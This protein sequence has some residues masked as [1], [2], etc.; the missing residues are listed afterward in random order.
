MNYRFFFSV[1]L[2]YILTNTFLCLADN[3]T[4]PSHNAQQTQCGPDCVM[5]IL[6]KNNILVT[7]ETIFYKYTKKRA[8]RTFL[9][10]KNLFESFGFKVTGYQL[11]FD[12]LK[13]LEGEIICHY[14]NKHFVILENIGNDFVT[15]YNPPKKLMILSRNDFSKQ[16]DGNVLVIE[17]S[18]DLVNIIEEYP[19]SRL[20]ADIQEYHWGVIRNDKIIKYD[21]E[22]YNL[23]NTPLKIL[24]FKAP[25]SCLKAEFDKRELQSLEKGILTVAFD[26]QDRI[27]ENSVN[28][29]VKTNDS[30][31]PVTKFIME[32]EIRRDL[33]YSPKVLNLG[34]F[35]P[36]SSVIRRVH[37]TAAGKDFLKI[38]DVKS[39]AKNI[40]LKRIV[41]FVNDPY[42]KAVELEIA[43]IDHPDHFEESV[44]ISFENE[45]YEPVSVIIRGSYENSIQ[46]DPSGVFL[47]YNKQK[48]DFKGTLTLKSMVKNKISVNSLSSNIDFLK[49]KINNSEKPQYLTVEY[50]GQ[51]PESLKDGLIGY[52]SIELLDI[53][54]TELKIPVFVTK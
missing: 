26:T 2:F 32:G 16:W 54:T 7:P 43:W 51:W 49:L 17:N 22:F 6:H 33:D 42:M 39:S 3:Q 12:D 14:K 47:H 53:G 35:Q 10:M 9:D 4:I 38:D 1:I 24:E 34:S 18:A 41:D 30:T 44:D 45:Q 8:I 25:C 31:N 13:D 36:C 28:V 29:Y 52:I 23:G 15:V 46:C 40:R 50:S 37:F 20:F 48:K 21:F 5:R 19:E 27:G 11:S